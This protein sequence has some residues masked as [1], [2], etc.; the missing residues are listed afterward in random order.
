MTDPISDF[1]IRIKNAQA[2]EHETVLIPYSKFKH[3][4]ARALERAGLVGK[5]ERRGRKTRLLEI[6][7]LREGDRPK[8]EMVRLLS[9]PSRR[10]YASCRELKTFQRRGILF[11]TTP[12]GVLSAAEAVKQKVGGQLI[13]EIW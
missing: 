9:K 13:A 3:T 11:L 1:F 10:R 5:I 8:V 4:L 7:L 12:R 2:A 6:T